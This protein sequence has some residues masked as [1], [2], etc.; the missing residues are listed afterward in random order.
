MNSGWGRSD[1]GMSDYETLSGMSCPMSDRA[2]PSPV[3]GR[4]ELRQVEFRDADQVGERE[5]GGA[6]HLDGH[7][8]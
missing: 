4:S 5:H 6:H 2:V 3:E 1:V 7:G 8:V